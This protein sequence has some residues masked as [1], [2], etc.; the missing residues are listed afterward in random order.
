METESKFQGQNWGVFSIVLPVRNQFL[1]YESK[2]FCQSIRY[3]NNT[4]HPRWDV[5]QIMKIGHFSV[6]PLL[7]LTC[8]NSLISLVTYKVYFEMLAR[9]ANETGSE[10]LIDQ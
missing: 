6:K 3:S 2:L 4:I 8:C 7:N 10:S 5:S 1:L 9:V